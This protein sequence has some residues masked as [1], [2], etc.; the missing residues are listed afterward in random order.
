MARWLKYATERFPFPVY[1]LLVG[2]ISLSGSLV[3]CGEFR[4]PGIMI[5]F[6]GLFLFFATLRLMDEYKDFEKDVVAH[7]E[8]PLP[9]GLLNRTEVHNGI[10]ALTLLMVVFAVLSGIL[11]ST[12]TFVLFLAITFYL[13]LMY[14]EFYVPT[15]SNWPLVYAYSHQ[16][17]LVLIA[18]YS[19]SAVDP[20]TLDQPLP[21]IWGVCVL[22]GFF[23][24]EICRKLDPKSHPVLKTYLSVYGPQITIL[25][26]AI[27]LGI[28]AAASQ[29]IG[30]SKL[31]VP[32]DLLVLASSVILIV[33]PSTYKVV[34]G[35]ATINLL[36]HLWGIVIIEKVKLL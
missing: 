1:V 18:G 28:S 16:I 23:T 22:G 25:L 3:A 10:I 12:T 5:S 35:L 20:Q 34:E 15:L 7:P 14:K 32:M 11:V 31:L 17:I 36:L 21:W 29:Y 4:W 8:R 6:L 2:G 19:V 9:R 27:N 33:K 26:I 30:L 24:Y 13:W